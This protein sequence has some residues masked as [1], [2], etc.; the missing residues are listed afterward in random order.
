MAFFHM[1]WDS[2][3][4]G[5]TTPV[6]I[7]LPCMKDI[8]HGEPYQVLWLLHGGGGNYSDWMR[9]TSIERYV[10]GRKLAVV[11]PEGA[12]SSYVN[13]AVG[14]KTSRYQ[15][16]IARELRYYLTSILPL[17]TRR[18][19]NFV[20]GASMGGHG[21]A[22]FALTFPELFGRTGCFSSGNLVDYYGTDGMDTSVRNT[23][24]VKLFGVD[25]PDLLKNTTADFYY[26]MEN[27]GKTDAPRPQFYLACGTEDKRYPYAV[28]MRNH[29]VNY[30]FSCTFRE[31]PGGHTWEFWDKWVQDFISWLPTAEA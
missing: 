19:D 25:K 27:I 12:D 29:L 22:R 20:A 18:E 11:M 2:Q 5:I 26:L 14:G 10:Q 23:R 9:H 21:A 28:D 13:M 1:E 31:G 3:E 8:K 7:I 6:N 17:S 4:L 15:T 16:Y 24:M 30:G